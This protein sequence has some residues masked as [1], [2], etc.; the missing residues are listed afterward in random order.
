MISIIKGQTVAILNPNKAIVRDIHGVENEIL[1][2]I[3]PNLT[4][5]T[6]SLNN[7]ALDNCAVLRTCIFK[8]SI[9]PDPFNETFLTVTRI[10]MSSNE[11]LIDS[12]NAFLVMETKNFFFYLK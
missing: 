9:V 11:S 5:F 1:G 12:L 10:V 4:A 7:D 2:F 6:Y 8:I 3:N